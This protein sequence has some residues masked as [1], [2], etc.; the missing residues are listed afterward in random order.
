MLS[1]SCP[2][3]A[4][5][6][7][8]HLTVGQ[9]AHHGIPAPNHV[10]ES[11]PHAIVASEKTVISTSQLRVMTDFASVPRVDLPSFFQPKSVSARRIA[12]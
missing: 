1:Y 7:A 2:A 9:S 3:A 4:S 6:P 10:F 8:S 5:A 12:P 11:A